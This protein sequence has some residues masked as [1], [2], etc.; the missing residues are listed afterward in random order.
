MS[1]RPEAERNEVA[2]APERELRPARYIKK[3]KLNRREKLALY[4]KR[5]FAQFGTALLSASIVGY[6]FLQLMLNV[7]TMVEVESASY[8]TISQKAELTAYLFRDEHV[9]PAG[10]SGTACYLVSDGEKVMKGADIA[11]IYTEDDDAARQLRINEIDARIE[12]LN[13]S[14]VSDGASTTNVSLIDESIAGVTLAMIRD[15][16]GN[17]LDKALRD[18]EELMVLF[19]RRHSLVHSVSYTAELSKLYN[20]RTELVAAMHGES[21]VTKSPESGYFYSTVDGYENVFTSEAMET[22]TAETFETLS[23]SVPDRALIAGSAGKIVDN[24]TWYIAVSL[25]KRSAEKFRVGREYPITFQYSNGAVL[26]MRVHRRVSRTDTDDTIVV[27]STKVMPEGFDYSRCQTVELTKAEYAGLRISASAIRVSNGETGV[28]VVLGNR[29]AFKKAEVIYSYA[30]YCICK[31]PLNPDYPNQDDIAYNSRT[32]L[33]LHDTVIT[34]GSG[35]YDGMR[36][37]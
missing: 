22:L 36:L 7:G 26:N 28:F 35:I 16:D 32:E 37:T 19:N 12:V 31:V 3:K 4:A 25:D 14:S 17:A 29:V 23:E 24:S 27:F 11:V 9:I 15:V 33:S 2:A 5:F 8:A 20:E 21:Y 30:G 34:E 6:V 1:E 13:K 10:E 18:R